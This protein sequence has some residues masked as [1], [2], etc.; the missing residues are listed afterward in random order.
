VKVGKSKVVVF[1]GF[2]DKRFLVDIAVY[3]IG[4]HKF[5]LA[6]AKLC[7]FF[8]VPDYQ[9]HLFLYDTHMYRTSDW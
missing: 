9:Y 1:G 3:D 6:K 8:T 2:A 4:T 5:L 7:F